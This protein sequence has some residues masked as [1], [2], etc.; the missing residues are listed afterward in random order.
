MAQGFLKQEGFNFKFLNK[1]AGMI[2]VNT[3]YKLCKRL[4]ANIFEKC[5]TQRFALSQSKSIKPRKKRPRQRSGYGLQLIEKQKARFS[6]G[7]SE[8]QFEKYVKESLLKKTS[9][10]AQEL[11]SFLEKRL[12]NAVYRIG[13]AKTRAMARQAVSHGHIIVNERRV[14]IP[15]YQLRG[16]DRIQ[17]REGSKT[18]ELFKNLDLKNFTEANIPKWLSFDFKKREGT[19]IAGPVYNSAENLFDLHSVIEFYNR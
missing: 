11:F 6:Y 15:S 14:N 1:T 12:D 16:G 17:I 19:V 13:F 4:G 5:Q 7:M 2:K 8:K 18:K 3:K 10:P 9:N